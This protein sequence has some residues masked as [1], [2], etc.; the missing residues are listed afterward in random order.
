M[1]FYWS[2]YSYYSCRILDYL[3]GFSVLCFVV[4]LYFLSETVTAKHTTHLL[5]CVL[6]CCVSLLSLW[7]NCNCN[8]TQHIQSVQTFKQ[9][10]VAIPNSLWKYHQH[11][12]CFVFK[13]MTPIHIIYEVK[14]FMKNIYC[15]QIQILL[16]TLCFMNHSFK[17]R[18]MCNLWQGQG[19]PGM[20]IQC[21]WTQCEWTHHGTC[22]WLAKQCWEAGTTKGNL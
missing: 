7:C 2:Y 5:Y 22:A 14:L 3:A 1:I 9:I 11:I 19:K 12:K 13:V 16:C 15:W 6:F 4:S 17:F 8:C 21:E 18:Y 10:K 20:Q